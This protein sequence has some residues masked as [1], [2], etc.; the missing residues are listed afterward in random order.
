[1]NIDKEIKKLISEGKLKESDAAGLKAYWQEIN[2]S[3]YAGDM[4]KNPAKP[5]VVSSVEVVASMT[6]EQ[7]KVFSGMS[8]AQKKE[9]VQYWSKLL[10]ADFSKAQADDYSL[11][12]KV[13]KQASR[14]ED[15]SFVESFWGP[16]YG[17]G[18]AKE[19]TADSTNKKKLAKK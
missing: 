10:P 13:T 8:D 7:R 3:E 4:V 14:S 16:I 11:T 2:G 17:S 9:F 1:M 15:T 12:G 19:M 18:Y 6:K 5:G